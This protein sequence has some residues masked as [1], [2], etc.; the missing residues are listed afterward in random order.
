[1][2][3]GARRALA[4][5]GATAVLGLATIAETPAAPASAAAAR[6][7]AP[8]GCPG[9]VIAGAG[10]AALAVPDGTPLAGYGSV[11]RRLWVPDVL[12]RYPHAFWFKPGRAEH[13]TLAARA[14]VLE[15]DGTRVV[16]V[17]VD[18]V[19]VDRTFTETVAAQLARAGANPG[20]LLIAASHT[21]S[22]PGA[23]VDSA[24]MGFVA[25][26]RES[27]SVREAVVAAVVDAVRR[28]DEARGPARAAVGVVPAPD[29]ARSRF[30]RPLDPEIVV[31]AVRR[32][33]GAPVALLWNFAIHGTMLGPGNLTFSG[34]V[35]GA[36]SRMLEQAVRAPALFVNGAVGDVSP[37]RHGRAALAEA[38][39]ALADAVG[40]AW[41]RAI[42]VGQGALRARTVRVDL[43]APRLSLRNCL[44]SWLPAGFTLPLDGAFPRATT[45][46]AVA[47]GDTVWLALPGE[48]ATAL[49][50]RIKAEARHSFRHAFV[51]GVTN[52]YVGYLVA[53]EDYG[54]PSYVTCGSVY[55][56]GTGDALTKR[57]I[58]LL[59]ELLPAGRAR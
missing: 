24:L 42:P 16:W 26:D 7:A 36:A 4:A 25:V 37:A 27:P 34:D 1:M 2:S 45:V 40:S 35:M 49:G 3:G 20:V 13:E 51:A 39:A 18:L 38:A 50:L 55:D 30:D 15:R 54:R 58:G 56:V 23:F 5:L 17:A 33:D 10:R 53:A 46:T 31:L 12:G 8:L 48:P 11:R 59:R 32:M 29:I 52:D 47:L 28:A 41:A 44:G 9:C 14:L 19:A 6:A 57:A 22:G 43:P 21:H